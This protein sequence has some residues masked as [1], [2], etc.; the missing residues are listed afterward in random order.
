MHY[1]HISLPRVL[2][3]CVFR[4]N[5]VEQTCV[6]VR[7][8]VVERILTPKPK[9]HATWVFRLHESSVYRM[10]KQDPAGNSYEHAVVAANSA[11]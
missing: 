7:N 3:D 4:V 6:L 1:M 2:R 11:S 10:G 8:Y 5:V 9:E